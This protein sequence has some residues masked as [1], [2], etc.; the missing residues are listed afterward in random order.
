M[1]D[2]FYVVGTASH[3]V[4]LAHEDM[5][6]VNPD[7]IWLTHTKEKCDNYAFLH[8]TIG[9]ESPD[10]KEIRLANEWYNRVVSQSSVSDEQLELD[11]R[12][13]HIY[14]DY[15]ELCS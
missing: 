13:S 5:M 3:V 6:F 7:E 9:P 2:L 4:V 12:D 14:N 8:N 11:P 10:D 1:I 15:G